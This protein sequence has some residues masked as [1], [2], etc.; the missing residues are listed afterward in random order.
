MKYPSPPDVTRVPFPSHLA[1]FVFLISLV[2]ITG[3]M[4]AP[5]TPAQNIQLSTDQALNLIAHSNRAASQ[6]AR[7]LNASKVL[8]DSLTREIQAYNIEIDIAV[9][10]AQAAAISG[11]TPAQRTAAIIAAFQAV[12]QLPPAAQTFINNPGVQSEL[13]NLAALVTTVIQLVQ[14]FRGGV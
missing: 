5:L 10:K 4:H 11:L 3:C 7:Q 14:A 1:P 9:Q 8:S 12:K 2:A 6:T 13:Q